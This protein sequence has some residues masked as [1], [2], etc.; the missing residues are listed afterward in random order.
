MI[1]YKYG[2]GDCIVSV[3]GHNSVDEMHGAA[4]AFK[5]CRTHDGSALEA[6]SIHALDCTEN[7]P[8][9][10]SS[11]DPCQKKYTEPQ[12]CG[13]VYVTRLMQGRQILGKSGLMKS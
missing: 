8:R 4:A 3:S 2:K 12:R 10:P 5:L 7:R 13:T 6:L 11:S 1:I 9:D